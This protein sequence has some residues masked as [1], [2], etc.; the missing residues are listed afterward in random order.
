MQKTFPEQQ[1]LILPWF[2]LKLPP[3]KVKSLI[4]SSCWPVGCIILRS[5]GNVLW[6]I[7]KIILLDFGLQIFGFGSARTWTWTVTAFAVQLLLLRLLARGGSGIR[8]LTGLQKALISFLVLPVSEDLRGDVDGKLQMVTNKGIYVFS[9]G[10]QS[11][12][13]TLYYYF[14]KQNVSQMSLTCLCS[15]RA[16][17]RRLAEE[18]SVSSSSCRVSSSSMPIPSSSERPSTAV[19]LGHNFTCSTGLKS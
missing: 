18:R 4:W 10:L 1:P 6:I 14:K 8:V 16:R 2:T 19:Y 9:C 5:A 11:K 17:R 15:S 13:S 7:C 12:S 3:L